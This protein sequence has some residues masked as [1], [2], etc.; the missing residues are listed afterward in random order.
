MERVRLEAALEEAASAGIFVVLV[1]LYGIR[2][3]LVPFLMLFDS[4]A[5][6]QQVGSSNEDGRH[7]SYLP[8]IS[9]C[10]CQCMPRSAYDI[11]RSGLL[12]DRNTAVGTC[13]AGFVAHE[14]CAEA[15]C[16]V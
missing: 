7:V 10:A 5:G 9:R 14:P 4:L 2:L 1:L 15:L 11:G 8:S 12:L 13:L 16:L 3:V 6:G